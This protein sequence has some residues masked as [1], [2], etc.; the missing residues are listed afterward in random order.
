ME[1]IAAGDVPAVKIEAGQCAKIMTGAMMPDGAEKVIRIEYTEEKHGSMTPL[2]HEPFQNVV[3]RGENLSSGELLLE[4]CVLRAQEIGALASVGLANIRVAIPPLVGVITTGSELRNPG[5]GLG[6]GQIYNSNGFQICAQIASAGIPYRYFGVV[7][8]DRRELTNLVARAL[9]QCDVLL[10]S[11][12]VSM[13]QYDFVPDVLKELGVQIR[14]HKLRLKPGKPT[15]F[16]RRQNRFVFGLP[17]NPVST[18]VVFE[19]YVKELLFRFM[20]TRYAPREVT[21]CLSRPI[22][23]RDADRT[24]FRPVRLEADTICPLEYHGST[25]LNALLQ[26]DGLVRI[27]RGCAALEAGTRLSVRVL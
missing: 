15:L 18:F 20:G 11:G 25:H 2:R 9:E 24:E 1:T 10:L 8:D 21:A 27:E 26:A 5:T 19:I 16:G 12:G 7:R 17:G 22:H 14:F 4:P 6:P 3:H 13:G 23:R